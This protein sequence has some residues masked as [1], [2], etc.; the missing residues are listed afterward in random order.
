MPDPNEQT[1]QGSPTPTPT[2]NTTPKP[3]ESTPTPTPT[4]IPTP[5][6]TPKAPEK[7]DLKIPEG[8]PLD[9]THLERTAAFA[10]ERGLSNEE[11]QALLERDNKTVAGYLDGQKKLVEDER[12]AWLTTAKSDKEIGGDNHGRK[13]ELAQ[14][15]I[16]RFGT[17]ALQDVLKRTGFGDYPELVR[18]FSRIGEAMSE[19]QL[20][21]PGATPGDKKSPEDILYDKSKQ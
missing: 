6:G 16:A 10:K 13:V 3:D 7:Y 8:S 19:D 21:L 15:V 1:P 2:P 11:A 20:I 17:E 5:G 14:R 9:A 4:P 18:V 12:K